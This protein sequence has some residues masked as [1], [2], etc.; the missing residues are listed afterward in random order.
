M[1]IQT[2][3]EKEKHFIIVSNSKQNIWIENVSHSHLNVQWIWFANK[4]RL[5][6][7]A[8]ERLMKMCIAVSLIERWGFCSMEMFYPGTQSETREVIVKMWTNWQSLSM[9]KIN[10]ENPCNFNCEKIYAFSLAREQPI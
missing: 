5:K 4:N 1:E 9:G 6:I 3:G 7:R 10:R 8:T 2:E